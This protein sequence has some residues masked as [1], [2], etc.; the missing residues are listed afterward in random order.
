MGDGDLADSGSIWVT[1]DVKA[2][3]GGNLYF[4]E[5]VS[6]SGIFTNLHILDLAP[7]RAFDLEGEL[8]RRVNLTN[9][10]TVPLGVRWGGELRIARNAIEIVS[11]RGGPADDRG[12]RRTA[13]IAAVRP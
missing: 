8:Y 6:R 13:T 5:I 7:Q 11:T 3:F 9:L 2:A 12:A 10:R 1:V 4:N